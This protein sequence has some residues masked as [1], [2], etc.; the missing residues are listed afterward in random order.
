MR[1]LT[2]V[3]MYDI[4]K[5]DNGWRVSTNQGAVNA[6]FVVVSSCGYSLLTAHRLGYA[7]HFSCL[8]VAGSFYFGPQV[9]THIY[10]YIYVY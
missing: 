1:A 7:R 3:E 2:G 10:I 9:N 4:K 6:K 8:P 5:T